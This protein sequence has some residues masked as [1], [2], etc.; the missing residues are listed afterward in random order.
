MATFK[1]FTA[2]L[3]QS[4]V[5]SGQQATPAAFGGLQARALGDLGATAQNVS[6]ELE[7]ENDRRDLMAQYTE[8]AQARERAV[9]KLDELKATGE[10]VS[11]KMGEFLNEELV[12]LRENRLTKKGRAAADI[13]I[14]NISADIG[15]AARTTDI[16][17]AAEKAKEDAVQLIA[18]NG[19]VL[20]KHPD[21]LPGI[22]EQQ[23][24]FVEAMNLPPQ[25]KRAMLRELNEEAGK[26]AVRGWISLDP[27]ET[28]K[29]I[30]EGK[31]DDVLK[32]DTRAALLGAAKTEQRAIETEK[33]LQR[34]EADRIKKEANERLMNDA[35]L[36]AHDP[37]KPMQ[38]KVSTIR[39]LAAQ[40]KL[41]PAQ[42]SL[43]LNYLEKIATEKPIVTDPGVG[44]DIVTRIANN[45]LTES[46]LI[47]LALTKN[48]SPNDFERWMERV[49]EGST[50]LKSVRGESLRNVPGLMN[51]PPQ[52]SQ[53][54]PQFGKVFIELE[55]LTRE[56]EQEFRAAGKNPLDYYRD[57]D[58]EKDVR[59]L[60]QQAGIVPIP[61]E[62]EIGTVMNGWKYIGGDRREQSSWAPATSTE[63]Q[64]FEQK[65]KGH[66]NESA[67]ELMQAIERAAQRTSVTIPG[68][69]IDSALDSLRTAAANY[70]Q[71]LLRE[72]KIAAGEPVPKV[73][74]VVPD[75]LKA[76]VDFLNGLRS[77]T[78]VIL[79]S[80]VERLRQLINES[81]E[82][83]QRAVFGDKGEE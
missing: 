47:N 60:G 56:R 64:S 68:R 80:D 39:Q 17:L 13:A 61:P 50:A 44:I 77:P 19:A 23:R 10:P 4:G 3:S 36:L 14:A 8:A 48:I 28:E 45:A 54:M 26:N 63:V 43:L 12:K 62:L 55:G 32:P 72:Q 1:Q 46:E 2:D 20:Q 76:V 29:M 79:P 83:Q 7:A 16:G 82:R 69:M 81:A 18:S 5:P 22:L 53:L 34:I 78:R 11:E 66:P 24:Q 9:K 49:K 37:D 71:T 41:E 67:N 30:N 58:Y 74:E 33:R 6:R 51:V 70:E 31:F 40:Q 65:Q 73:D 38:E 59:K 21:M 27:Y 35:L 52:L 75:H 42:T 57:G 15:H 25:V